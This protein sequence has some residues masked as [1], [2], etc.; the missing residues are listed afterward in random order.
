MMYLSAIQVLERA[1][2][3]GMR[4]AFFVTALL[5]EMKAVRAHLTDI[6][7]VQGRHGTIYECGS[8]SDRGQEWLV[9]VAETGAGTHNAHSVVAEGHILF[10]GFEVQILVGVG[11]SRK[12]DDAP[13]GSV[14]A[15]EKLYWPYGGKAGKDGFSHRPAAYP[16]D[17][18]LVGIAKK[19]RRE[20]DWLTRI[21][22]PRGG[23]LPSFDAYP[24]G[25]PPVALVAP[26][27]SIEAVL[28]E[29]KSELEALLARGY[30]DTHVV[31]MEGYG[32]VFAA[33]A[34]RTPSIVIRGVSDMTKKKSGRKDALLQPIAASHAAAFGF[35]LLSHWGQLEPAPAPARA[36]AP[37][38]GPFDPIALHRDADQD[39]A[40]R[41]E[42]HGAETADAPVQDCGVEAATAPVE[43]SGTP[44]P[45]QPHVSLVMSVSGD[46]GP[47]DL[48]RIARFE[49]SLR[50]IAADAD[51][52]IV[53][54]EAGSLHLFIADPNAALAKVGA[55]RLRK[56][57][58]EREDVE[59]LGMVP[60]AQF[61]TLAPIRAAFR[62]ASGDLLGWPSTLPDGERIARP[63]HDALR[64]RL[65]GY[66]S[67]TTALLGDPGA[68]KS[69]LL[70]TLGSDYA[71]RG[72][73]VLAIKADLLQADIQTESDL[74]VWLGLDDLP[75]TLIRKLA[76]IGPVLLLIDQLDALAQHLDI[77]VGRL[78]ALLNLVRKLGGTENVHIVLSSRTFEFQ[79]DVRLKSVTAESVMLQLPAWSDI[80]ALL[81]ARGVNAAGWPAD[82]QDVMRRPQALATYLQ[83][84][85]RYSSEPFASY[86]AM[87]ERLWSERVLVGDAAAARE[88]LAADIAEQMA[89]KETL[90]LPTARFAERTADLR[91]LEAAGVLTTLDGTVGFSHQTL[92]EFALARGFARE[93]GR[94]SS[95]VLERQSSLFLRPKL[96]SGLTY[97]RA[98]DC[99]GYHDEIE[100]IWRTDTLRPHLRV[101]LI[102]FLGAQQVPTDREALLMEDALTRDKT[103]LRGFRALSGSEGWFRRFHASFIAQAMTASEETAN[104]QIE[105][106]SRAM[107]FAPE[108]ALKLLRSQWLPDPHHDSRAW[109]VLQS[110]PRWTPEML[111]IALVIVERTEIAATM[112]DH[113][114]GTIGVEQPELALTLV[115]A[116]L[117]RD[118]S[119]AVAAAESK[120]A[121][122]KP[123]FATE[124]DEMA[125]RMREDP[126]EP[127]KRLIEY[128]DDWDSLPALA[129]EAPA[130]FLDKLW[131]WYLEAFE[132]LA[133]V[134]G[135]RNSRVGYA[136]TYDADYRFEGESDMGLPEH[137]LLSAAR[138]AVEH[139]AEHDPDRFA[140]WAAENDAVALTPVQ[141][142]I[143]HGFA[144][145]P[146]RYADA[147]LDFILGDERRYYL[148]SIHD[149]HGT[150]KALVAAVAPHWSVEQV[151]RFENQVRAYAPPLPAEISDP[152]GKMIWRHSARRTQLDLLRALP[153]QRLS[154]AARR[155]VGEDER[156]F[157]TRRS[158]ATFTGPQWIGS[159]LEADG[160]AKAS[161]A[162]IV[163]AFRELP[164]ATGWDHPRN[165]MTG[166]N[167]QLSRAFATFAK[168]HADRAIRILAEL[169]KDNGTRA[170][171]YVLDA[172]AEEGEPE[173]VFGLLRDVVARGFDSTEF[174]QS[175]S[176]AL[177]R[178]QRRGARV[179]DEFLALLEGWIAAPLNDRDPGDEADDAEGGEAGDEDDEAG[180]DAGSEALGASESGGSDEHDTALERSLL[181]G[182]G[183]YAV[184][185]GGEYPAVEALVH[186][187]LL[188]D[189]PD[190]AL[191]TLSGYLSR[192]KSLDVWDGLARFLPYLRDDGSGG[193]DAFLDRLFAAVPGLVGS[194]SVSHFLANARKQDPALVDRH[195]DAWR[196]A[197]SRQARQAYGEIV[198]LAAIVD[199]D[200]PWTERRL[201]GIFEDDAA[202]DA[203]TGVALSAANLFAD[204]PDRAR[205]TRMLIRLLEWGGKGVWQATFD[206]FRAVDELAPDEA[207]VS[208]LRAISERIAEA[209]RLDASFIV[210]RLSTMLPH[211]APLVAELALR[212]VDKWRS[213]L[214]DVR[215][216]TA[217]A[218]A[219]LIDLAIT[220]HRLGPDTRE[221][222]T[223]L[224]EALIDTDA[225]EAR[226]MLDEIDNRFRESA[227]ATRRRRLRRRRDA[228]V[229]RRI[230]T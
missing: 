212:L 74:Q 83:L 50:A 41:A 128:G 173:M 10:D 208:L 213:E 65:D 170:A 44:A 75:S 218:T 184:V 2:Q 32:A 97:L 134:A 27:A 217:M 98:V 53:R 67:T 112:I 216:A 39:A 119:A 153:A 190:E 138:I 205:A 107:T 141:R 106:L 126:R 81:E 163:N 165:W 181:W 152:K 15:S 215:T 210:E 17:L 24:V 82:A 136:L 29:P 214:A 35:E 185:P 171:A 118:L 203:R 51:I 140:R 223:E 176:R 70:A 13:L 21:R 52:Q 115:R 127:I 187:R 116:R 60:L 209:P 77:R 145:Q 64:A 166:G 48:E 189:E 73:P 23:S 43:E 191:A 149:L 22:P 159:P 28:D 59:V 14:V 193:R 58:A 42:N 143:A 177:E 180:P 16:P 38:G 121:M 6:G 79:H 131:P 108:A 228:S 144:H 197:S 54:A 5:L 114:A 109:W 183:G 18:R 8:F 146:E 63:E 150:A 49:E 225:Y 172:L 69:A 68:G 61:E 26:I 102:D 30:G 91:G 86:Q 31:E 132:A 90:W 168:D 161:D 110:V 87:L 25:Y 158:G 84:N 40:K 95:F 93:P 12:K 142:L 123:P 167:I 46:F 1:Q 34:E 99:G 62:A 160:M 57:L 155:Q 157:G 164:D 45:G 88:Q 9:V 182:Y 194:R 92:F 199:P 124:A 78:N 221:I 169:N 224:I 117:S 20:D 196:T 129:E 101:L 195:L 7:S 72:W 139:A 198:G 111:D 11:G 207:T 3:R 4:R 204:G 133:R 130:T 230:R 80:L 175:A 201:G 113:V 89:A 202:S 19:I 137:A 227:P 188:R 147:A 125:W 148:G 104:L 156:R 122:P 192:E 211:Q 94:L 105:I 37:P 33:F 56:E 47:D 174:R 179:S 96:W 154:A 226:Q 71:A 222:G 178:L 220:L 100:T 206:I 162:D 66:T 186:L 36:A 85:G 219:Q 135:E 200:L 103:R 229:R 55:E 120:A 76:G 151:A